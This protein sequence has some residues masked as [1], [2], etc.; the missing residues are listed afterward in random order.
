MDIRKVI[1]HN[2]REFRQERIWSQEELADRAGVHRTYISQVE[3][4]VTNPTATV[5]AKIADALGVKPAELLM[6]R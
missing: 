3:R 1:A 6:D 5:I 4:A 2:V